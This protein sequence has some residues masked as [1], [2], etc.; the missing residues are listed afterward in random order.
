MPE[1]PE[2]FRGLIP[3]PNAA[4][5]PEEIRRFNE[6]Y[7][8]NRLITVPSSFDAREYGKYTKKVIHMYKKLANL[9]NQ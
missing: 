9:I 2:R 1:G 4:N 3:N 6:I 7:K 5:T 8:S